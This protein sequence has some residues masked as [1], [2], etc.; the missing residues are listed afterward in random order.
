MPQVKLVCSCDFFFFKAMGGM[1]SYGERL[2][3]CPQS[4]DKQTRKRAASR[5][6]ISGHVLSCL[7]T[8]EIHTHTHSDSA[9]Q[10]K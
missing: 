5:P 8:Q 4:E 2:G 6:T 1:F 9:T 10:S 7:A 3:H